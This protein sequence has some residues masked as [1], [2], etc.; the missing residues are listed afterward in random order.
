MKVIFNCAFLN[1]H[2][3]YFKNIIEEIKRIGGEVVVTEC[4][5]ISKK[6][7]EN[8]Q[9]EA[10]E[11]YGD[12]DFTIMPDEACLNIAG[13][14]IYINHA[15]PVIPQNNFYFKESYTKRVNDRADYLFLSSQDVYKMYKDMGITK[16][17]KIVGIPKLSKLYNIKRGNN[18]LYAPTGSWKKGVCSLPTIDIK[19]VK[20]KFNNFVVVKHPHDIKDKTPGRLEKEF[21]NASIVISDYSSSGLESIILNIPTILVDNKKWDDKKWDDKKW[22]CIEARNAAIRVT[23]TNELIDAI[24]KYKDDPKFLEDKRL[25]YSNKLCLYKENSSKIFVEELQKLL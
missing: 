14:G 23:N 24:N 21:K 7:A 5:E 1:F 18:I 6:T 13:K 8:I 2:N 19:K 12:Y 15:I 16:P 4:R 20:N 3:D 22:I 25:E 11:K 17:V 10:K 9:N